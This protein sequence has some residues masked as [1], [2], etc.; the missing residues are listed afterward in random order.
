MPAGVLMRLIQ[1]WVRLRLRLL[2][3]YSF[4]RALVRTCCRLHEGTGPARPRGCSRDLDRTDTARSWK[5]A[6][7]T[8]R[9]RSKRFTPK[10]AHQPGPLAPG[11]IPPLTHVL[12]SGQSSVVHREDDEDSAFSCCWA[13]ECGFQPFTEP[14]NEGQRGEGGP[15]GESLIVGADLRHSC[16]L[17]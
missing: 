11:R 6:A 8:C 17:L 9:R 2:G 12:F 16:C 10:S 14:G 1:P 7:A 4:P 15:G 13:D 3:W 5:G